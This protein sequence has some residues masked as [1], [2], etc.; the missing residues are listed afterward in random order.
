MEGTQGTKQKRY[1][2]ILLLL[3][4]L[5]VNIKRIFMD[6]E[7]DAEYAI[8]M[9][10]RLATGD[11]MFLQMWEPHQTS[12]F[13]SAL[14]IRIYLGLF[15]TTTGI[16][17]YL[18]SL[19]VICK[20]AV[21]GILYRTLKGDVSG[22]VLG[23]ACLFFAAVNPKDL[24][25]PEFSNMQ[26]WFSALLFC[27]LWKYFKQQS[28]KQWLVLADVC[29]CLEIISYPSCVI[30]FGAVVLCI[31][32]FSE[33]KWLD[34]L[35][36]SCTCLFLGGGYICLFAVP[37]GLREFLG[38]VT[39]I[40]AGD[41]SHN[42]SISVRLFEYG[43]EAGTFILWSLAFV[44]TAW[45]LSRLIGK[46]KKETGRKALLDRFFLLFAGLVFVVDIMS[47]AFV[48]EDYPYLFFYIVIWI[49]GFVACR[50]CEETTRRVFLI[51]MTIS[52]TGVMATL[53]LTNL[54]LYSTLG[55][56]ILGVVVSLLCIGEY[57]EHKKRHLLRCLIPLFVFVTIFRVGFITK[58]MNPEPTSI[59]DVGGIVKS[60]P[61]V[62]MMSTYMGP[63]MIN[64][65]MEEWQK[66]IHS[67]DSL[68]L[69]G[70]EFVHTLGYL[71]EDT[72]V[73]IDSTICTPT[74]S[75]KLLKYWEE[76]PEK[77]PTVIAVECWYGDLRV[78]ED[79]WVLQWMEDT[80]H[81]EEVI[82]GAYWRYYIH[83]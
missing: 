2:F 71:Y 35:W 15:H 20:L 60:G 38:R 26:L 69:V 45:I 67:G 65:S 31:I 18:N 3:G 32:F 75:D 12:A 82:D 43:K 53:I 16:V 50:S 76:N 9:S 30:V 48:A 61:A 49:L 80:W 55:Y 8:A 25:L 46:W 22:R 74:Y 81:P 70:G 62:G 73:A 23:Y 51:G 29:L 64:T 42:K 58:P 54:S 59:L 33:K 21:T 14:F 24:A 28:R 27:C 17:V 37:S 79:H 39:Q 77:Y 10:Y 13:L 66:Y 11:K 78:P 34:L 5:A 52:L 44:F 36:T 1:I 7:I 83:R 47:I 6:F 40:M 19:G 57:V 72:K 4:V 56:G 63:Y 41:G 68:L